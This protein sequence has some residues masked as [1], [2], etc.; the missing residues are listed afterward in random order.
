MQ[1]FRSGEYLIQVCHLRLFFRILLILLSRLYQRRGRFGV[2]DS[3]AVFAFVALIVQVVAI[4]LYDLP[5]MGG[6]VGKFL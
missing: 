2:D 5:K 3:W 1:F 4:S 6:I